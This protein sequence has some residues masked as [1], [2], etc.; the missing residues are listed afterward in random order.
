MYLPVLLTSR[1]TIL[2]SNNSESSSSSSSVNIGSGL[3]TL[4]GGLISK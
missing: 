3:A 1:K 4:F 2:A